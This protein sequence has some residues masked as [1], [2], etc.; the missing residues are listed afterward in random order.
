MF[1]DF[2]KDRF[3]RGGSDENRERSEPVY[4]DEEEDQ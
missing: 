1:E 4:F 3:G 2:L